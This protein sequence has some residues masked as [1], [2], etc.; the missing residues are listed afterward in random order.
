MAQHAT[1]ARNAFIMVT[2][3]VV[4]FIISYSWNYF[5]M[6]CAECFCF[7][8]FIVGRIQKY[9]LVGFKITCLY[10]VAINSKIA[11]EKYFVLLL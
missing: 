9:K 11:C 5:T 10:I 2:F 3:C 7:S 1:A 8:I 6:T 4:F